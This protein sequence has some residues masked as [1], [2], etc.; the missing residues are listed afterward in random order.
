MLRAY[1]KIAFDKI[2]DN[3]KSIIIWPRQTGKSYLINKIIENFVI[4][5]SNK[6]IIFITE[7]ESYFAHSTLRIE[8]D[9]NNVVVRYN[10]YDISFIN[11]N[12]LIFFSIRNNI[13]PLLSNYNP[14]LI[15]ADCYKKIQKSKTNNILEINMYSD[16]SKCKCLYTFF[17]DI[18]II[19]DIDYKNDC[20]INILPYEKINNYSFDTDESIINSNVVKDLSYKPCVL[21]DY[22]NLTFI[23]KRKIQI[24]N[25]LNSI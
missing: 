12:K 17:Y 24:L 14:Q 9:I 5:N 10:K 21:L 8:K 15:V 13:F 20:Y 7:S 16:I 1:Q 25:S 19:K 22:Y 6:K 2:N 23:R 3:D 18:N 11:N 4:N